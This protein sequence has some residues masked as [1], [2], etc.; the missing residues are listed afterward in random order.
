MAKSSLSHAPKAQTGLS[1]SQRPA[2]KEDLYSKF[3]LIDGSHPWQTEIPELVVP[4]KVRELNKGRVAYFNYALAKEM[5]LISSQHPNKLNRALE[6]KII[7]TFSICI[8]NEYDLK[9]GKTFNPDTIRPQPH[10]A[11]RYLQLQ[12][13]N[14]NG[15]TSGD[16]RSIWNGYLENNGQAWDISSRGTGVTRLAPGAVEA[17]KPLQTGST[18]FGYGCG[19]ADLDELMGSALMSEIYYHQGLNTERVLAIID[20]GKGVG[21]GVRASYCLMRPAHLFALLKQSKLEALTRAVDHFIERQGRQKNFSILKG[22]KKYD[23]MLRYLCTSYAHF[24]AKLEMNYMFVWLD[25]DGDNMLVDA[26]IIDYGSVR[27]FGLFHDQ[28]R[29]DDVDRFSTN[30]LE[31]RKKARQILQVFCQMVDYLKRGK[32]Q[33]LSKYKNSKHLKLFDQEVQNKTRELFL[34]RLGFDQK[35]RE[36]LQQKAKPHVESLFSLFRYFETQKTFKKPE[37]LPD[38]INHQPIFNMRGLAKD[39]PSLLLENSGLP[40][41]TAEFFDHMLAESTKG[42]DR[43]FKASY[44]KK[45]R[46]FQEHYLNLIDHLG[47]HTQEVLKDISSRSQKINRSDRITGNSTECVVELFMNGLKRGLP[48]EEVQKVMEALILQQSN[49]PEHKA[50]R[51]LTL[52]SNPMTKRLLERALKIIHY[53]RE[54]I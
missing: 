54:D 40:I 6:K 20:L 17:G 44:G 13:K 35:Q 48:P 41:T 8:I 46:L 39:Y 19:T 16:G 12:H 53:Y 45:I 52:V 36:Q 33:N 14:K 21:I 25:W 38:G 49:Y 43:K 5:G 2:V 22:A 4:Y 9:T 32:K 47:S 27:Q 30:I 23:H 18:N 26:G 37:K 11:T 15:K 29:Y 1:P 24:I 28:Y 10:M 50:P 42:R 3:D 7:E 34:Y 51:Q 31:Q